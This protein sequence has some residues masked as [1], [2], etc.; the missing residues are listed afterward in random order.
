M[1]LGAQIS[2]GVPAFLNFFLCFIFLPGFYYHPTVLLLTP[3]RDAN[4]FC[5][6]KRIPKVII[7][8]L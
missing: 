5:L 1:N 7:M 4:D 2:A 6:E 3:T 8:G